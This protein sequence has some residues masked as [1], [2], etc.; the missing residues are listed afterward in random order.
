MTIPRTV[1]LALAV[2]LVAGTAGAHSA[3]ELITKGMG[4]LGASKLLA[5]ARYLT[6]TRAVERNGQ[7]EGPREHT[8]DRYEGDYVLK[9]SD[10]DGHAYRVFFNINT[11]QGVAIKDDQ[12]LEGAEAAEVLEKAY[13]LFI[14]DTY[15]LLMPAK[16]KD[17]GVHVLFYGH[18][19][20]DQYGHKTDRF[21]LEF[22]DGVGL[23]PGDEYDVEISSAGEV[24]KWK[25][26]LQDGTEG[27]W[28]WQ[29]LEDCGMG[30]RFHKRKYSP[31]T[32]VAIVYPQVEFSR[33]MDRSVFE[34][35]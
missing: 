10:R 22:D 13:A 3:N 2:V 15:W 29:D 14:N 28:L 1:I 26:T 32:Q 34:P 16:L 4:Y 6:F 21:R 33:E 31:A 8:W 18:G 12:R 17:P 25:Y 35:K 9:Y 20:E 11:K 19:E 5:E 30:L 24:L 23:T 7:L 27:E